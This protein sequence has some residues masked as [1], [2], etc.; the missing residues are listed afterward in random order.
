[1][2]RAGTFRFFVFV[3]SFHTCGPNFI[4]V[5]K[6]FNEVVDTL[7]KKINDSKYG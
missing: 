4:H 2:Y 6:K 7:R 5:A 1:M 3:I